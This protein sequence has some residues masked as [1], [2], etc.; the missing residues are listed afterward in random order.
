MNHGNEVHIDTDSKEDTI[1]EEDLKR[2]LAEN[3]NHMILL[4]ELKNEEMEPADDHTALLNEINSNE[5]ESSRH[6][7][8]RAEDEASKGPV[9]K[10]KVALSKATVDE[11]SNVNPMK[12]EDVE[13]EAL[14]KEIENEE[15][16][17]RNGYINYLRA[18]AKDQQMI[19]T[20]LNKLKE[21]AEKEPCNSDDLV[22]EIAA[23]KTLKTSMRNVHDLPLLQ[24]KKRSEVKDRLKLAKVQRDKLLKLIRELKKYKNLSSEKDQAS[25]LMKVNTEKKQLC[26]EVKQ[27]KQEIEEE[28]NDLKMRLK[29]K[30]DHVMKLLNDIL[31]EEETGE[32]AKKPSVTIVRRT[33]VAGRVDQDRCRRCEDLNEEEVCGANGKTYRSLCRAINCAGLHMSDISYGPCIRKVRVECCLF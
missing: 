19:I 21:L 18:I 30:R 4:E 32:L 22:E 23:L 29:H 26:I 25:S 13:I 6:D 7:I 12:L 15:G 14:L 2:I 33:R 16:Q 24:R 1:Y 11:Y 10:I 31:I 8:M 28:Y 17:Q 9:K 27:K 20:I 3:K 5:E